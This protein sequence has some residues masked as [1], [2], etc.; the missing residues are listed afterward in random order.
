MS[1]QEKT[2][3]VQLARIQ[4]DINLV[5]YKLDEL[6]N[7]KLITAE[8]FEKYFV[9]CAEKNKAMMMSDAKFF[10]FKIGAVITII[11][12]LVAGVTQLII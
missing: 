4:G 12:T 11:S 5:N 2:L 10:W 7:R 3:D 8:N 9:K 1:E 6:M